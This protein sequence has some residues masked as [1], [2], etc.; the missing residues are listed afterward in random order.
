MAEIVVGGKGRLKGSGDS[1]VSGVRG[2]KTRRGAAKETRPRK[3]KVKGYGVDLLRAAAER[4]MA[5]SSEELAEAMIS[6]ALA[7]RMD[8][9]K[10][11]MK[12]G[13]EEKERK[14]EAINQEEPSFGDLLYGSTTR[15]GQVWDGTRWKRLRKAKIVEGWPE[16]PEMSLGM[17]ILTAQ[18]SNGERSADEFKE[19][20][21]EIPDCEA[22]F[23]SPGLLGDGRGEGRG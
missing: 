8:N 9:V 15:I 1:G 14:L 7:G 6:K 23:P 3:R 5:E 16:P 17:Q 19:E 13:E 11:L 4:R 20:K 10:M 22:P 2:R 18:I 12:L 21:E